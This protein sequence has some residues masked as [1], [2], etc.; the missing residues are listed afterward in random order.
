LEEG[1]FPLSEECETYM[2]E[3][4]GSADIVILP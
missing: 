4:V 1:F 2:S 3:Q